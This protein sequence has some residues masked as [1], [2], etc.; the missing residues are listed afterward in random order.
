M[1][2]ML[3]IAQGVV[4]ATKHKTAVIS[5]SVKT[6]VPSPVRP[7]QLSTRFQWRRCRLDFNG[8]WQLDKLT[9]ERHKTKS[10]HVNIYSVMDI[11][12]A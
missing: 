2:S 11:T 5:H 4:E 6:P 7:L 9:G 3:D 12:S 8:N 10:A 1:C